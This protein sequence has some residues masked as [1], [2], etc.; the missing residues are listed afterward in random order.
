MFKKQGC[1]RKGKGKFLLD[2]SKIPST[3]RQMCHKKVCFLEKYSTLC[4]TQQ[5]PFTRKIQSIC[6]QFT[7]GTNRLPVYFQVSSHYSVEPFLPKRI[8]ATLTANLHQLLWNAVRD[9][10]T[11]FSFIKIWYEN[12]TFFVLKQSFPKVILSSKKLFFK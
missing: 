1:K 4:R 3:L 9:F 5:K 6:W 11:F 10:I 12:N 8:L 2:F 7:E